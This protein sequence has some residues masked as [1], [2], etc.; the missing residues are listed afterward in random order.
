MCFLLVSR[1]RRFGFTHLFSFSSHFL[2][3][4]YTTMAEVLE[5]LVLRRLAAKKGD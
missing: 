2:M 5:R 3:K 4:G 1:K